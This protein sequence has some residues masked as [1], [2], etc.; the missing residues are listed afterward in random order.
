M[1][2][3]R[4]GKDQQ[5]RGKYRLHVAAEAASLVEWKPLQRASEIGMSD[6]DG[7]RSRFKSLPERQ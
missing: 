1:D 6:G 5:G 7:R 3:K 4:L 2:N